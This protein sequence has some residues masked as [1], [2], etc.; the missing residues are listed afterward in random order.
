[1]SSAAIAAKPERLR[2]FL[3]AL[4]FVAGIAL[5]AAW[6]TNAEAD[7]TVSGA[8]LLVALAALADWLAVP[9]RDFNVSLGGV[10]MVCIALLYG[11][12]LAG[13][14]GVVLAA[15]S[16]RR[17][18]MWV[19]RLLF[20]ASN[21][22]LGGVAAGFAAEV[23][24]TA[25]EL[26]VTLAVVAAQIAAT[27][28]FATSCL[29]LAA[30]ISLDEGVPFRGQVA[31]L[32]RAGVVPVAVTLAF[33]PLFVIAWQ[34]SPVVAVVAVVPLVVLASRL[35]SVE[36]S[37]VSAQSLALT[38]D[39]T[40]LG[41]RRHFFA[42]LHEAVA[43]AERKPSAVA[44]CLFDLN[45]FKLVNDTFGH[46]AGDE[47]LA[48]VAGVLRHNGEAFRLGGDEFAL[49]LP[50]AN[51]G[52]AGD[53]AATVQAR[54]SELD[55]FGTSATFGLATYPNDAVTPEQLLRAADA[56]LYRN[57]RERR[58]VASPSAG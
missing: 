20:N 42:E 31:K 1:V 17:R 49:L 36:L 18:E 7:R 4:A 26:R 15:L 44:L 12:A 55:G 11:P 22:A 35:R 54:I 41:N 37:R 29:L 21:L 28:F 40:S 52:S 30:A 53:V 5:V 33:A 43:V 25:T 57:K 39:L 8:V 10:L 56:D 46:G 50:G 51:A 9:E 47:L 45:G 38:D 14:A 3:T 32:A 48:R 27:V 16:A 6:A 58:A 23:V 13:T 24:G 2:A 19:E 34:R